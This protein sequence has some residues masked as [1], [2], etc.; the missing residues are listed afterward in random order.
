MGLSLY[1]LAA[2]IAVF[3]IL[4]FYKRNV[5]RIKEDP[6]QVAEAQKNF[7]IGAA[8]S[9]SLPIVLLILGLVNQ[10]P[11]RMQDIYLP[12]LFIVGLMAF[13]V[14]F[15]FLQRAVGTDEASKQAVTNFSLVALMVTNAIPIVAIV[16][17]I[18]SVQ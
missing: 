6:E 4:M 18:I 3:G 14:F 8:I 11:V 17:L 7:F 15:I 16:F 9:E 13:S 10:D 1:V 2:A 5:E 12:G